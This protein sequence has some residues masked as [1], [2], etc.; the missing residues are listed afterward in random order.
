MP[1]PNGPQFQ[2]HQEQADEDGPYCNNCTDD[3]EEAMD[4][5]DRESI[6]PANRVP[7]VGCGAK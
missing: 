3:I 7:C 5:N 6:H 4:W 2:K 1:I